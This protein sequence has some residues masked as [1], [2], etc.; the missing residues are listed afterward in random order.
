MLLLSIH[1]YAPMEHPI[2][3]QKMTLTLNVNN[4]R[5]IKIFSLNFLASKCP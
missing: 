4:H 1:L 2:T 3:L 5:Y